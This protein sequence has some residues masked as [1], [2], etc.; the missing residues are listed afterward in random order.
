MGDGRGGRQGV[1]QAG[2]GEEEVIDTVRELART[3]SAR[4]ASVDELVARLGGQATD[5][6]SNVLVEAPALEGVARASVV[7]EVRGDEPALLKL[8][9][10]APIAVAELEKAFG[11]PRRVHPDH[12]GQPDTLVFDLDV[13]GEPY[14]IAL[15]AAEE[16]AESRKLTLRR[17]VRLD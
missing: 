4:S 5:M 7:R 6:T 2:Q 11:D 16:G 8:E 17:D 15:L 10:S 1:P 14:T 13:E 3:L 12:L 9:L